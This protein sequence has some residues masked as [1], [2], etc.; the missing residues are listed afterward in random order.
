MFLKLHTNKQT[1]KQTDKHTD[2]QTDR[3]TDKQTNRR[4]KVLRTPHCGGEDKCL[5]TPHCG[6]E[7]KHFYMYKQTLNGTILKPGLKL[8]ENVGV[9]N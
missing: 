5:G 4:N 6:G 1:N 3:Q 2:R 7:N 9:E 8:G